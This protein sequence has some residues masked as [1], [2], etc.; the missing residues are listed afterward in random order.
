MFLFQGNPRLL[1][2]GKVYQMILYKEYTHV[3]PNFNERDNL[4]GKLVFWGDL[5][6]IFVHY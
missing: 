5:S 3:E 1:K 6:N 2:N 4:I